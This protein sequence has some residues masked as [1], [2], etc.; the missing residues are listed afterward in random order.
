MSDQ[1]EEIKS[2]NNIVEIVGQ[3]VVLKKMGRHHKGLCPF[4]AEKTPSFTVS[5]ELGFYKC[6]GCGA[7]GDSIKFL[8]EVEGIYFV[9]AL[10][11]LA[12]R[13]GIK[14]E[15]LKR[16]DSGLAKMYE[17]ME[18]AA[19]Y[20]HW[21]LISGKSGEVARKYL[22]ERKIN[23]KTIETFNLGFSM[24]SWDGLINYLHKKKSY[25]LEILE[26]VGLV[27]RKS[28]GGFY[29]KF[30]GRLMFPLQDA[31][32]KVVGFTGRILPG[33]AKEGEPKYLNSPET[34]I[35]HKGKMLYGFFQAK[36]D[37]REK[38]RVVLVE[39]Q[40]DMISSFSAGV[41][42]TVAVGGTGITENQ[43]EMLARL[44]DKILISLDTDDAG[45][46]ALKRTV[47]LAE[48]RG[49]GIKIVQI[50][51]GKDPDE[52]A[53][54]SKLAW[55]EMIEK[56]VDVY[57]FV[58]TR[59]VEKFGDGS[60]NGVKK[61]I[62]EVVPFLSKIENMVV[63]EVWAKRLAVKIEVSLTS[64]LGEIEKFRSGK[65]RS[66]TLRKNEVVVISENKIQKMVKSLSLSL[67][68]SGEAR[69]ILRGWFGGFE[70]QGSAWKILKFV[71]NTIAEKT[72]K[73]LIESMPLEIKDEAAEIYISGDD[74]EKE[75]KK[76]KE[77]AVNLIREL[78]KEEKKALG[79]KI[80]QAQ[81]ED[82][83]EE[84]ELFVRLAEL[85]KRENW[86]VSLDLG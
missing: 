49:L 14:L 47:D 26:R 37:I 1:V 28:S 45:Y 77:M 67:I 24:E 71:L 41:G 48:K 38:K 27:V 78:V 22:K 35:Y 50:E 12:L 6:F 20:Y 56:A 36:K 63:R 5:E 21:L 11:R 68:G 10:E 86:L 16:E 82:T 32:G 34:E 58:I 84:E 83:K 61:I 53:R 75:I 57:D 4:H 79:E 31:G 51:G 46:V 44:S 43:I 60:P 80:S 2:K 65:S 52:I 81:K 64:V 7:G 30:R 3:Y 42:E 40:M 54:R 69:E 25:P 59:S 17:V 76:I 8:M 55:K 15:K 39:G 19:R 85:N 70:Y 9:E 73:E 74:T 62:E 29:D 72:D 23:E 13:V 18:L 66:E 33:I